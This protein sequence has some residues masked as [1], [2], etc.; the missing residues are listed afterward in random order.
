VEAIVHDIL[1]FVGAHP[2]YD[3]AFAVLVSGGAVW[4]A[5]QR[6]VVKPLWEANK[7]LAEKL[8]GVMEAE[9]EM[10]SALSRLADGVREFSGMDRALRIVAEGGE[11]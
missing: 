1:E 6:A 5:V 3:L 8:D 10:V 9:R 7:S 4:I 2:S 11:K